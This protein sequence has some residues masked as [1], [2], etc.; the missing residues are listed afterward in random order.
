LTLFIVFRPDVINFLKAGGYQNDPQFTLYIVRG[1]ISNA[2]KEVSRKWLTTPDVHIKSNLRPTDPEE[3]RAIA[4]FLTGLRREAMR[5]IKKYRQ[6]EERELLVLDGPAT[7]N[8]NDDEDLT[9]I[10]TIPA[11]ADVSKQVE[12][13]VLVREAFSILTSRQQEVVKA[14]V[15]D[16]L[17]EREAAKQLSISQ[18]VV[19]CVK[20]RALL[21]LRKHFVLD[22][23]TGK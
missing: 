1:P 9:V 17:T 18:S 8:L 16:G 6:Q 21:K 5:L 3:A 11:A 15:L 12:E 4:W 10:D 7:Q 20:E 2:G 23:P 13:V 19:H 22:E 14:T